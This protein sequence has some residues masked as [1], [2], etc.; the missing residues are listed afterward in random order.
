MKKYLLSL[1]VTMLS[2]VGAWAQFYKFTDDAQG[3]LYASADESAGPAETP[4]GKLC[5]QS[6]YVKSDYTAL[7]NPLPFTLADGAQEF[8]V[9]DYYLNDGGNYTCAFGEAYVSTNTYA[10]ASATLIT[11]ANKSEYLGSVYKF[12]SSGAAAISH[13]DGTSQGTAVSVGEVLDVNAYYYVYGG[14]QQGNVFTSGYPGMTEIVTG[15]TATNIYTLTDGIYTKISASDKYGD[16]K[17]YYAVEFTDLAAGYEF[18]DETFSAS[19][20]I[21]SITADYTV[22]YYN[23]SSYVAVQVNDEYL[24]EGKYFKAETGFA[25]KTPAELVA[26][27]YVKAVG[28]ITEVS[29]DGK[30]LTILCSG[31]VCEPDDEFSTEG[32][33]FAAKAVNTIYPGEVENS[34]KENDIYNENQEYY[35]RAQKYTAQDIPTTTKYQLAQSAYVNNGGRYDV[36]NAGTDINDGA[37]YAL[38][39]AGTEYTETVST[40]DVF[41]FNDSANGWVFYKTDN[42]GNTQGVYAG[43]ELDPSKEYVIARN[44]NNVYNNN[45]PITYDE[46]KSS[47]YVT[48]SP[49]INADPVLYTIE[50]TSYVPAAGTVYDEAKTYYSGVSFA[51]IDNIKENTAYA[52]PVISVNPGATE[53]FVLNG[54]TYTKVNAGETYDAGKTYYVKDGFDYNVIARATLISDLYM[55]S[56]TVAENYW[57]AM[58]NEINANKYETVVFATK[59]G[60]AEKATICKQVTQA[61]MTTTTVNALDFLDVQIDEIKSPDHKYTTDPEGTFT[62]PHDAYAQ[63]STIT[64]LLLPE[65]KN[66][67]A[68]G[69]RHVPTGCAEN[70]KKLELVVM[71]NN[72]TCLEESAFS[73]GSGGFSLK[74]IIFNNTLERIGRNAFNGNGELKN[75]TFPAT[76]KYIGQYAFNGGMN[77]IYFLGA[78]APIVEKDAFGTEAYLNNNAIDDTKMTQDWF[79][80]SRDAYVSGSY[81]AAM[82]H[83]PSNLTAVQRAAYTDPTRDYHVFEY[84]PYELELDGKGYPKYTSVEEAM[85]AYPYASDYVI[86][87]GDDFVT[88]KFDKIESNNVDEEQEAMVNGVKHTVYYCSGSADGSDFTAS[89]GNASASGVNAINVGGKVWNGTLNDWENDSYAN[90]FKNSGFYDKYV[91][92]N[93]VW[94]SQ[95]YMNRAFTVASN[96][97]LWGGSKTIADGIAGTAAGVTSTT[98]TFDSDC[99][100]VDDKTYHDGEEY[101]GLHEFVLASFDVAPNTNTQEWDFNTLG[102]KNW[103]TIC[104]PVDMTVAEVRKAFGDKTQVCKFNKVSR[105]SNDKVK[106]GFT[107]EQCY[108]N[109]DLDAIAIHANE[110]Y[111]IRPSEFKDAN[112]TFSLPQYTIAPQVIPNPTTL[113]CTDPADGKTYTYSFVGNYLTLADGSLL[114]MQQY[115]YYLGATPGDPDT[116]KLFFQVG[117]TGNWKP[118]TCIVIPSDG[119]ADYDTFFDPN[120][121]SANKAKAISSYLGTDSYEEEG[122]GGITTAIKYEI[123]CGSENAPIYNL[124]GQFVGNSLNKLSRGVYVQNGKKFIVK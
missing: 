118:Y 45:D 95:V 16:G 25:S 123:E 116:H 65:I 88:L 6:Y 27:G 66:A 40:T 62:Y 77:D 5:D 52:T 35:T 113:S 99:D 14:V 55:T 63:N 48:V 98:V 4:K 101:M 110:A 12:T 92:M 33:K 122:N 121:N 3:N 18:P 117:T 74:T 26:L 8:A 97:K 115:C 85:L 89:W 42:Y 82:L 96:N 7:A 103:Y 50:G 19:Q 1:C 53:Y 86:N 10:T 61:M 106:L 36:V 22:Y 38:E 13:S 23:G 51:T 9:K 84:L 28:A 70:I 102:G 64:I 15:F 58:V 91:G 72:A 56:A 93:Y 34:V 71:P 100:G 59:E 78:D 39:N 31:D 24:G 41:K 60:D 76:L 57:Q 105:D 108:G 107:A 21:E 114:K 17:D 43:N 83:L 124:N 109:A 90:H 119:K 11:E 46:L 68:A 47:S 29:E 87:A 79:R 44:Q 73:K 104:V 81:M 30:T 120:R 111:M 112:H 2:F 37:Y 32:Y 94:P 75:L 80:I 67:N 69:H 49:Y 54:E 20:V